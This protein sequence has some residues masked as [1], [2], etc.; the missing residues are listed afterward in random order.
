MEPSQRK[1]VVI[2]S[3]EAPQINAVIQWKVF[4]PIPVPIRVHLCSSVVQLPSNLRLTFDPPSVKT[5][6]YHQHS[7]PVGL[8]PFRAFRPF[9]G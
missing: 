9:R 1:S 2:L 8:S 3:P 4:L 5:P 6:L 7:Q